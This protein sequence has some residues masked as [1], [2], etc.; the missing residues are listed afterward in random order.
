LINRFR[1]PTDA[2]QVQRLAFKRDSKDV[3]SRLRYREMKISQLELASEL[4][5]TESEYFCRRKRKLRA[6]DGIAA[7]SAARRFV[8][9]AENIFALAHAI[10]VTV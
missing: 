2:A 6:A 3:G 8:D 1:F 5:K 7:L 10:I 4:E 9:R